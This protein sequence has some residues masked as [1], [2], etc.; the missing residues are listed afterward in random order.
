MTQRTFLLPRFGWRTFSVGQIHMSKAHKHIAGA[1]K[2][3]LR[4]PE[5]LQRTFVGIKL[6]KHPWRT[7]HDSENFLAA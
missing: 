1:H 7:N 5:D 2:C 3:L 6:A 4:P